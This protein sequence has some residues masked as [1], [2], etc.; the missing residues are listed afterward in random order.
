[1]RPRTAV[2]VI[3]LTTIL[4]EN[5]KITRTR[6]SLKAGLPPGKGT[7]DNM[8]EDADDVDTSQANAEGTMTWSGRSRG[9]TASKRRVYSMITHL[10]DKKM[11]RRT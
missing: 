5:D 2:L 10:S 8:T 9:S 3:V 1:M 7:V 11:L 4:L 6:R